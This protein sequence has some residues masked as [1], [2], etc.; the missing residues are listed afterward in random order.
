[1]NQ[2]VV[3]VLSK[4][5]RD[6]QDMDDATAALS[7]LSEYRRMRP[8]YCSGTPARTQRHP[9]QKLMGITPKAIFEQWKSGRD[10]ALTRSCPDIATREPFPFKIVFEGKY[11]ESGGMEKAQAE[12]VTSIYQAFFYRALPYVPSRKKG[13]AWD[14]DYACM[15][16]GDVSVEGN[17]KGAWEK[18][19]SAVKSGFW[20]GANI[21]VMIVRG[22]NT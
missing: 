22:R 21:Y 10:T 4:A 13:P 17:L 16:A 5:I 15:L 3:P 9:F 6:H 11:F 19:P 12:L 8:H 20:E 1:L 14:Y 7:L 2:F 18:L